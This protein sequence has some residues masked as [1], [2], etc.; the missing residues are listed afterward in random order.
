MTF[1]ATANA[2]VYAGATPT[3]A[4]IDPASLLHRSRSG[5]ERRDRPDE[6]APARRLRRPAGRLR[7]PARDRRPGS[8]R[9]PHDHRGRLTFAGR[10]PRRP[11]RRHARRHDGVVAAPG[12]D[13]HDR[14]GRSGP[15][16]PGRTR[17]RAPS[18]SQPRD[19]DRAPGPP[20]LDA[21]TW[22]SS[23]STT[24]S[25]TSCARSGLPSSSGWRRSSPRGDASQPDIARRSRDTGPWTSRR[26]SL[27]LTRP[28][29]SSFVQLRLDRLRVD[30]GAGLPGH[31]GR[32]DRRERPLHPRP[33]PLLVSRAPSAAGRVTPE[34]RT[35]PTSGC[36]RCPCTRA[37]PMPTSTMS[38]RR[39]TGSRPRIGLQELPTEGRPARDGTHRAPAEDLLV[40]ARVQPVGR[41]DR[42]DT[43]GR[44]LL[45]RSDVLDHEQ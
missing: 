42:P 18:L 1:V 39:W 28:G 40:I 7:T 33:P 43:P 29:T 8:G 15:H 23:A 35:R 9:S 10:D 11:H 20:G 34:S 22:S 12:Q 27:A 32:G 5:G 25:R 6:G 38:S 26:S 2:A 41:S 19:R 30:R 17:R 37:W 21:T 13:H 31:A 16:R 24:G 44:Q 36:S 14:R 3:F 4:D 45:A